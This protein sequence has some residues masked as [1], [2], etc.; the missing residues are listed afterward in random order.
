MIQKTKIKTYEIHLKA[1]NT[2]GNRTI[3]NEIKR[4]EDP[5]LSCQIECRMIQNRQG[6]IGKRIQ[7]E[8]YVNKQA[9]MTILEICTVKKIV[10]IESKTIFFP[11]HVYCSYILNPEIF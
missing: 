4:A 1:N 3:K 2:T 7:M 10:F 5:Q 6:H 8:E 9:R 11:I